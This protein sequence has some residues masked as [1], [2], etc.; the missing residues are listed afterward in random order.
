MLHTLKKSKCQQ[1]C[2]MSHP[3]NTRLKKLDTDVLEEVEFYLEIWQAW[4][5]NERLP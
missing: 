5:N 4:L 2:K 1:D 3:I